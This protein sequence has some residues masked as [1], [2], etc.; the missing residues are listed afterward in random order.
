[1]AGK[2]T[3]SWFVQMIDNVV[4]ACLIILDAALSDRAYHQQHGN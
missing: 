3:P 4:E 1:M 2:Q